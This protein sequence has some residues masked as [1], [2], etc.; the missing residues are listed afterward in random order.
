MRLFVLQTHP[1]QFGVLRAHAAANDLERTCVLFCRPDD[2][3]QELKI[4]SPSE[5]I[6]VVTGRIAQQGGGDRGSLL[7][8]SVPDRIRDAHANSTV[9]MCTELLPRRADI[10]GAITKI[11]YG[12]VVTTTLQQFML[13]VV[14]GEPVNI[15][16]LQ[17]CTRGVVYY[18][19]E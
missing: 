18:S 17:R 6:V 10:D 15:G 9:I 12:R 4:A 3:M 11:D 5:Y 19:E 2:L 13:D 14:H 7:M 1:E 16:A 8:D